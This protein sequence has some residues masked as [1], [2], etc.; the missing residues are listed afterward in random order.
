MGWIESPP[1]FFTLSETGQY[2]SEQYIDTPV[3][4]LAPHEFVKLTEVNLYFAELTKNIF[5]MNHSNTCWS[6]IW[7]ITLGWTYQGDR[8]NYIMFSTP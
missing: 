1:Y 5:Q 6:Y 2:V 4:L 8:I 3:G 7:M